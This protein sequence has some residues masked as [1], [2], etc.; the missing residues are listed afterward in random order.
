MVPGPARHR[1]DAPRP[2]HRLR[3]PPSVGTGEPHGRLRDS[4]PRRGTAPPHDPHPVGGRPR[5]LLPGDFNDSADDRALR[6]FTS[7]FTSAQ[8]TAGAGFGFTW[9]SG[10]PVVRIDRILVDGVRAASARTLPA[11]RSD[12]LP[13]AATITF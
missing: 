7:R 6:P 5:S 2:P 1:P 3:G 11:A 12:H 9:P 10:F 4:R 13:V 8:A